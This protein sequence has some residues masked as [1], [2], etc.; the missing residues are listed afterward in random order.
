M[1]TLTDRERSLVSLGAAIASNCVPCVEYHV[2]WAK[3]VGLTDE[4]IHEAL[5]IADKVRQV[6]AGAVLHAALAR[7]DAPRAPSIGAGGASCGCA[8]SAGP[9]A[10]GGAG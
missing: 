8:G 7:I 9:T 6:P 4:Q 1:S 5:R 10:F 3:K 2:P